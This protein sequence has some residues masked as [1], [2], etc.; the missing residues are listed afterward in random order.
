MV[1]GC[2]DGGGE[3]GVGG[4]CKEGYVCGEVEEGGCYGV[5]GV[6]EVFEF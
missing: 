2:I 4:G 6:R 3:V 5:G 1:G